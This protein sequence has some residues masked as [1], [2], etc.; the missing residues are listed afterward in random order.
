MHIMPQF[1]NYRKFLRFVKTLLKFPLDMEG[2][3]LSFIGWNRLFSTGPCKLMAV[4]PRLQTHPEYGRQG[5]TCHHGIGMRDA[6]PLGR[7]QA[8]KL[9]SLNGRP[10]SG[11]LDLEGVIT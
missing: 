5:P 11:T 9:G 10:L 8:Y 6:G 3:V 2:G 7:I 4:V 1:Q